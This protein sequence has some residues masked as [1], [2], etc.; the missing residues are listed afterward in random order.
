MIKYREKRA[1]T[2]TETLQEQLNK[3]HRHQRETQQKLTA[4]GPK[5]LTMVL[6]DCLKSRPRDPAPSV[7]M[8]TLVLMYLESFCQS[9]G[10]EEENLSFVQM[11]EDVDINQQQQ[12]PC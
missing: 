5:R 4:F 8:R 12:Q 9:L 10:V 1:R 3:V 11:L 6:T 2:F 7:D